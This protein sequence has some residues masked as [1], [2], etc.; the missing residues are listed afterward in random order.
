MTTWRERRLMRRLVR[1][2][3][4]KRI[5]PLSYYRRHAAMVSSLIERGY[6]SKSASYG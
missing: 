6:V 1:D 3:E 2:Y 5:R 4:Q